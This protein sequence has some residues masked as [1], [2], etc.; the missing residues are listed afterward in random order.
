MKVALAL[1]TFA[2]LAAP[3]FPRQSSQDQ[4]FSAAGSL[5]RDA[6]AND[7]WVINLTTPSPVRGE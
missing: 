1:V 2:L 4:Q 6:H 5:S 3:A 7:S